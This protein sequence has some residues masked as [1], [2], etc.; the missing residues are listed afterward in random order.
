MLPLAKLLRVAVFA[1]FGA[2][3]ASVANGQIAWPTVFGK[4]YQLQ[5]R[6]SLSAGTWSVLQNNIAGTGA[7][8]IGTDSAA[9]PGFYRVVTLP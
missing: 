8:W 2:V 6:E 7:V 3:V 1:L 5:W 9:A 4:R